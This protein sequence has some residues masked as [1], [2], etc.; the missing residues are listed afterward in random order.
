M[1]SSGSSADE[2]S[3]AGD[4]R[5]NSTFISGLSSYLDKMFI[6]VNTNHFYFCAYFLAGYSLSHICCPITVFL[7]CVD[8]NPDYCCES[9]D[10]VQIPILPSSSVVDPDLNPVESKTYSGIRIRNEFELNYFE[11]LIKFDNF[12]TKYSIKKI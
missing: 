8:L 2:F 7:R 4:S 6:Q 1:S 3:A 12:S 5:G 11:K 10:F 9:K